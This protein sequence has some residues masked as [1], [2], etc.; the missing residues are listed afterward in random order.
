VLQAP[1]IGRY[2]VSNLLGV[3]AA[4]RALGVPLADAARA[5]ATLA[6]VPGRLECVAAP[7]QP[8]VAV[9]YAHTPDA[10]AQA[11]GALRPVAAERGG[12]LTCVF[13]CGGGR[14]PGKRPRMAEAALRGADR[15]VV[16]TDNPRHEAPQAIVD[17][18]LQGAAGAAPGQLRVRLDRAE[19]IARTL[20][21]ATPQ[22]VVL[23]AG[24]GHE[25]YQEVAGARHPFSD[26]AQVRAALERRL[27]TGFPDIAA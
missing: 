5:C 4:L 25:D 21:E 23:V 11:L 18:V 8:L 15:V 24:K 12:A 3:V 16:T 20:A 13:G 17:Q 27:H 10:L 9:D 7:G 6:P 14:D 19:A 22:D 2:N 1:V 26:M